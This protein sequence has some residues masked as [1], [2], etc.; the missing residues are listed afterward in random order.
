MLTP[1]V[2]LTGARRRFWP[3]DQETVKLSQIERTVPLD[4]P[5]CDLL[6]SHTDPG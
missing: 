3:I 1:A 5:H 6:L 4:L 2:G